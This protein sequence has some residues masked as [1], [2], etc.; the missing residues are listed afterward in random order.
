MLYYGD[1]GYIGYICRRHTFKAYIEAAIIVQISFHML[2][3]HEHQILK[4]KPLGTIQ[5]K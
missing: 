2:L 5:M 3:L 1:I 4:L